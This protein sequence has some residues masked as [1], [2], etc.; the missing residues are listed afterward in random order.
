MLNAKEFKNIADLNTWL[1]E[2]HDDITADIIKVY[3][4]PD[5]TYFIFYGIDRI[6]PAR[7]K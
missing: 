6:K 7:D 5:G 4:S 1:H 3:R 2:W